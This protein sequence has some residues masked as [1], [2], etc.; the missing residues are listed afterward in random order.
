MVLFA[1]NIVHWFKRLSLSKEY[2]NATL[3]TIRSDLLVIPARMT[4]SHGK[5]IVKLPVDY[6][7]RDEFLRAHKEIE[8]LRIPA[9][10]RI[11]QKPPKSRSMNIAK[12]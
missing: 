10:F 1:A 4:N 8:A 2:R 5:N 3:D 6:H 7:Y 11:C 9:N 12:K